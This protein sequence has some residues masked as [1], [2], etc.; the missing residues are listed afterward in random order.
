MNFFTKTFLI[1]ILCS[2]LF[3]PSCKE[4]SSQVENRCNLL[5]YGIPYALDCPEN[6]KITKLSDSSL[7]GVSIF[8][9]NDFDLQVFMSTLQNNNIVALVQHLKNSTLQNPFFTKFI[10]EYD[11]GA[12]YQLEYANSDRTYAFFIIKVIGD[13][14]LV[15]TSGNKTEHSES[16]IKRMIQSIRQGK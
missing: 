8:N 4:K 2:S 1:T 14:E 7:K 5:K 13:N 10:E 12:I 16:S 9:E 3:V 11:D 6:S 15:F